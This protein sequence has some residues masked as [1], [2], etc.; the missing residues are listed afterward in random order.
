MSR[1]YNASIGLI[2]IM[3]VLALFIIDNSADAKW[4]QYHELPVFYNFENS[5]IVLENID[6]DHT[7]LSDTF[8]SF[9][10]RDVNPWLLIPVDALSSS[11]LTSILRDV[12]SDRIEDW[13]GIAKFRLFDG[14]LE[15]NEGVD[16]YIVYTE[17]FDS[18]PRL[19]LLNLING[20]LQSILL[21]SYDNSFD[22][23]ASLTAEFNGSKIELY[24]NSYF[25]LCNRERYVSSQKYHLKTIVLDELGK[26][27]EEQSF[28]LFFSP[29]KISKKYMTNPQYDTVRCTNYVKDCILLPEVPDCPFS[30]EC[31][32]DIKRVTSTPLVSFTEEEIATI[33]P[34]LCR[35]NWTGNDFYWLS[36]MNCHNDVTSYLVLTVGVELYTGARIF[37]VNVKDNRIMSVALVS[38]LDRY[39]A[40]N[41]CPYIY[42]SLY[43]G[44]IIVHDDYGK[45]ALYPMKIVRD[46]RKNKYD[47][48]VDFILNDADEK[49]DVIHDFNLYEAN[50]PKSSKYVLL[51]DKDGFVTRQ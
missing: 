39:D 49:Y 43:K 51:L 29:Y 35:D 8:S 41:P 34:A 3:I 30:V 6:H 17:W 12:L 50:M 25:S 22:G 4:N 13:R 14:R 40:W 19:F 44:K 2:R 23:K 10:V 28:G 11:T 27:I 42:S 38:S 9:D 1:I 32:I 46:Y 20:R 15:I 37:M 47:V 26:L 16:S 48:V 45:R 5:S 21:V 36:K 7:M 24:E 33:G 31:T 18:R